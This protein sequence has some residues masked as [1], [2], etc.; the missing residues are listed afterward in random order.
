MTRQTSIDAYT[1]IKE[2]G[3][4]AERLLAVYEVL[5]RFGPMTQ[6]ECHARH[7]ATIEKQN[8]TPRFAELRALGCV[9][10]VEERPCEISGNR[11]TVWDVTD[12]LPNGE[13]KPRGSRMILTELLGRVSELERT[14]KDLREARFDG[15][16]QGSLFGGNAYKG[17]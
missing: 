14:V 15:S 9:R 7:F 10:I 1:Q 17:H 16:G 13:A 2:N 3:L 4:L 5:Y 11:C 12:G 6:G 8:M